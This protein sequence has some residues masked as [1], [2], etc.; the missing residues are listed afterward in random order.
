MVK[1]LKDYISLKEQVDDGDRIFYYTKIRQQVRAK[2]KTKTNTRCPHT[3]RKYYAKGM[4]NLCYLSFGRQKMASNC[5]HPER[6]NYALQMCLQCYH[7]KKH[8][9]KK[10][11]K[12]NKTKSY[13]LSEH[14]STASS[15]DE[16]QIL[17]MIQ[18]RDPYKPYCSQS[19]SMNNSNIFY[20]LLKNTM[21]E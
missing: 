20:E 13:F 9:T 10:I 7:K 18:K 12:I 21:L 19:S 3:L 16:M 8:I 11:N 5:P 1:I 17:D 4:C 6:M 14:F 15:C 2:N